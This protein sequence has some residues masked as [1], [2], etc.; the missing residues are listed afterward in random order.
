MRLIISLLLLAAPLSAQWPDVIRD[1]TLERRLDSLAAQVRGGTGIYVRHLA[2]GRG[3]IL[4]ADELFPTASVIKLP[5]L[6]VTFD[7]IHRGVLRFDTVITWADSLRYGEDR[8]LVNQLRNGAELSLGEATLTMITTSDNAASLLLQALVG[9]GA[10][11]NDWLASRGFDSTRVNSRTPGRRSNWEQYGWGQTTPREIAEMLVRIREGR[12]VSPAADDAMYRHLTRIYWNERALSQLPPWIQVASKQG[13]VS[14][15]RA[16]VVLVNAPS[17]DYVFA[18]M[19]REQ[20][21]TSDRDSNE[22]VAFIR[23]VS[24]LLWQYF[25]PNQDWQPPEGASRYWP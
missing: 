6:A 3:A 21:D 20:E 25:E 18:V 7:Q 10:T 14:R 22:G 5:I 19:T 8:S 12:L 2:T 1:T 13:M 11:I 16:E 23:N 15:S 17:G 4:R 24:R 9:G